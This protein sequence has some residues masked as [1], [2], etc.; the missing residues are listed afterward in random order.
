MFK[1]W[2]RNIGVVK[3]SLT[4][5]WQIVKSALSI[6]L[7]ILFRVLWSFIILFAAITEIIFMTALNLSNFSQ[8]STTLCIAILTIEYRTLHI[9]RIQLSYSSSPPN[10][11]IFTLPGHYFVQGLSS[12]SWRQLDTLVTEYVSRAYV[13][14][15]ADSKPQCTFIFDHIIRTLLPV[16]SNSWYVA[17]SRCKTP[18][19][20]GATEDRDLDT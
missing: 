19:I 4:R 17:R 6:V 15:F 5:R 3:K 16:C 18:A 2:N 1:L 11:L 8:S 12:Y 10:I 20:G 14:E 7:I 13:P 9:F